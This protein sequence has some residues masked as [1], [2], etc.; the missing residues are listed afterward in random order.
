MRHHL[1]KESKV[2]TEHATLASESRKGRRAGRIS[3][4]RTDSDTEPLATVDDYADWL[5]SRKGQVPAGIDL[6]F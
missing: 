1:G 2:S 5:L 4:A 6:D 3:D